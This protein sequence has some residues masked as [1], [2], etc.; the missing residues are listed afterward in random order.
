MKE[1]AL[2]DEFEIRRYRPS[3]HDAVWALHNLALNQVNAHG[4]NGPWDDDLHQVEHVYLLDGG[5]FLV[6]T[7][8]GQVVAMGAL[9]RIDG[10]CAEVKRMRVHPGWQRRGLGSAILRALE[11][12]ARELGYAV[13]R[14]DTTTRQPAAQAFYARS[15]YA[16]VGTDRYGEFDLIL[17]EKTLA[18]REGDRSQEG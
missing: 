5:E 9:K 18:G 17:Y 8:A 3:D 1:R 13:L 12:R 11:A 14:L 7:A 4:G 15:G 2:P 6:G 10:R 16:R